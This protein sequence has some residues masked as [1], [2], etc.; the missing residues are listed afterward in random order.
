MTLPMIRQ[1]RQIA[2][3]IRVACVFLA[4]C[5]PTLVVD[6]LA[7]KN[8][9]AAQPQTSEEVTNP[10]FSDFDDFIDRV[11][12]EWK[13]PGVAVGVIHENRV[14]LA[15]GYGSRDLENDLPVT[16]KTL[17]SIASI[18]KPFTAT[19]VAML[20]DEGK[21]NWDDRVHDHL[22]DFQ[23]SDGDATVQLS[24]RD[25]LAHR[26]GLAMAGLRWYGIKGW[27]EEHITPAQSYRTL[28]YLELT[29]RP[30]STFQYSNSGYL[31]AGQ[32]IER[33][34]EQS[35]EDFLASRLLV[36]LGMTTSNFSIR[37]SQSNSDHAQPY[38]MIGGGVAPRPFFP[39]SVV[40]PIGGI[41]SNVEEMIRFLQ[42]NLAQGEFNGTQIVSKASM[43][44]L[45]TPE[46][47]MPEFNQFDET[48]GFHSMGWQ[49][50]LIRGEKWARHTGSFP[51]FTA[52]AAFCPKRQCAYVVLTN[53]AY[54]P[55]AE[56]VESNI[57]SR[58]LG[59]QPQDEFAFYRNLEQAGD[60][61]YEQARLE[62]RPTQVQATSPTY[63]F[64]RYVGVYSNPA[65]GAFEVSFHDCH[66][67]WHH[68]GFRGPLAHYHYDTFDMEG[69]LTYNGIVD[70]DI[71]RELVS[72]HTKSNGEIESLSLTRFPMPSP[73]VF[74]KT[75]VLRR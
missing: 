22:H 34:S 23:L 67:R 31:I 48:T 70:D 64:E 38:G 74:A 16:S 21:L 19:A 13:V 24:V 2:I 50:F 27:P 36:P 72:F 53:L 6:V 30:R 66:L 9:L 39:S 10:D 63:P 17:F 52:I 4:L 18:T 65:Y 47:V 44:E 33:L 69:D 51:G 12:C 5:A 26:T 7:G 73:V 55:T 61:A 46:V 28:R 68:H 42:F 56:L 3:T 43:R 59:R 35:W 25:C 41:N 49:I 40:G 62:R 8:L 54:R 14:I 71:R 15:K 20:V 45:L 75:E 11:L 1:A 32:L 37:K 60:K 29:A 57:R 58:L